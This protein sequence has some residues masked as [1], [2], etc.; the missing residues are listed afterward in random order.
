MYYQLLLNTK[1]R[2]YILPR[3]VKNVDHGLA[4][5]QFVVLCLFGV[6]GCGNNQRP[7]S[8]PYIGLT[9]LWMQPC[10]LHTVVLSSLRRLT[11]ESMGWNNA[12]AEPETLWGVFHLSASVIC[13]GWTRSPG[14]HKSPPPTITS[15]DFQK[16]TLPI[17]LKKE[18]PVRT[19]QIGL[20]E[21]SRQLGR[22][23]MM[24]QRQLKANSSHF[25]DISLLR[26]YHVSSAGAS[27]A[28][29][30]PRPT[31]S[32]SPPLPPIAL[33][34]WIK[35]QTLVC[36]VFILPTR[37]LPHYLLLPR[38]FRLFSVSSSSCSFMPQQKEVVFRTHYRQ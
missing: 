27:V 8:A 17:V 26:S 30:T 22:L 6:Y 12:S 25:N 3:R 28:E 13:Q 9:V 35:V 32:P 29:T 37:P 5:W 14:L 23:P 19:L 16:K 18:E 31:L 15:R 1:G 24:G 36:L 21:G 34:S 7:A 4:S 10:R 33:C 20:Q 38:L 2:E 11:N